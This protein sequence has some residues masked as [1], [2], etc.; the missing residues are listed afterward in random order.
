VRL[1][2][3]DLGALGLGPGAGAPVQW[4]ADPVLEPGSF[5]VESPARVVDGRTDVALRQLFER[6]TD[7]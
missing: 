3:A 1:N 5:V 7:A 2:P 4:T 6:L